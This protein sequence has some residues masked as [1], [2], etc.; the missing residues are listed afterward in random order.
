[1]RTFFYLLENA[2]N[3]NFIE[4]IATSEFLTEANL[5]EI[6]IDEEQVKSIILLN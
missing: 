2:K 4:Y 1:M 3:K 5:Y 6:G